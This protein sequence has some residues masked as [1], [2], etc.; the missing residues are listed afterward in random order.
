M[1]ETAKF[2]DGH[3]PLSNRTR[4]ARCGDIV[5]DRAEIKTGNISTST[6]TFIS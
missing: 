1:V 6:S 2:N 5:H 4:I 3:E